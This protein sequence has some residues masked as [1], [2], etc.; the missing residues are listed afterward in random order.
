MLNKLGNDVI[1][2]ILDNMVVGKSPMYIKDLNIEKLQ[3]S[4][5]YNLYTTSQHFNDNVQLYKAKVSLTHHIT[6]I[7][8]KNTYDKLYNKYLKLIIRYFNMQKQLDTN[9]QER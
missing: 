9:L 5:I 6:N 2:N 3:Q 7:D 8:K 1:N 4:E